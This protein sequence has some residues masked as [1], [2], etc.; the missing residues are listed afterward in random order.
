MSPITLPIA[1]LK[2]ALTGLAKV[3][4]RHSAL[5][6]LNHIRIERTPDGWVT[7]T[8]TDLDHFVTVRSDLPS[9]G[10]PISLLVPYD[11]L[12]K[13]IKGRSKDEEILLTPGE[14]SSVS[15]R[16]AIGDQFAETKVESLPVE[17]FPA[18]PT[19]GGDP[20]GLNTALR[21]AVQQ[22]LECASTDET[23]L[24]LNGAFIDVTKPDAHY[25]IGT[26]GSH[27]YSSNSFN[28]PLK[29]SVIVPAHKFLGFRD[30]NQ[31][32]EWQLKLPTSQHKDDGAKI[33]I[34][35]RR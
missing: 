34:S 13:I 7:F 5:P 35:L 14:N 8:A 17:E 23:R 1:E 6:V 9:P 32:G 30:F 24:I 10:E 21:S 33:Q 28:L 19:I 27:L 12:I 25:V 18:L 22:A 31:D 4:H 16:A 11:A 26:N 2:P 29:Q 20:I 3:I 15:I